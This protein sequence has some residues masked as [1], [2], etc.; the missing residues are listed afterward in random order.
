MSELVDD[1]IQSCI[2]HTRVYSKAVF[3]NAKDTTELL[4]AAK[5]SQEV[6]EGAIKYKLEER[7][8]QML[9]ERIEK[10]RGDGEWIVKFGDNMYRI[11]EY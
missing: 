5:K 11:S 1:V 2:M 4:A 9:L 8:E 7:I 3:D 10:V 6:L